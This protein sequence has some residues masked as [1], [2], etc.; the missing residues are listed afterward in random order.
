MSRYKDLTGRKF[1]KLKVLKYVCSNKARKALFECLCECGNH[2]IV[3]GSNLTNKTTK[4]CGCIQ[5]EAARKQISKINKLG[6]RSKGNLN[7]G[8]SH[9]KIYSIWCNMKRRCNDIKHDNYKYYGGRGIKICEEWANDFS[10]FKDWSMS[11]GYKYG[12]TI[13]RIDV[14]GNY[15]PSNCRWI[16]FKEQSRNRRNTVKLTYMN[17]EKTLIEWCEIY[18]IKYKLAHARYKKGW[19]FERIFEL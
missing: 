12:L 8:G 3:A 13:D 18:K 1:G 15:E 19:A 9:T 6:I 10:K 4:S 7:H 5:K 14:N 2:C 17:E 11:N 16:P